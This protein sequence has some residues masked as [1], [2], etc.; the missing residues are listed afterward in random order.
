M[1]SVALSFMLGACDTPAS[2]MKAKGAPVS[3]QRNDDAPPVMQKADDDTRIA[4]LEREVAALKNE[5]IA[6]RP[7]IAKIDVMEQKF[8]DLS[9]GLDRI[10]ATY[11]VQSNV[12]PVAPAVTAPVA[13]APLPVPAE[14][15]VKTE[16]KK[17]EPKP[18][19][20][21]IT[22]P[23]APVP[24]PAK[25]VTKPVAKPEAK[26]EQKA[27]KVV[28][29]LRIGEQA[30]GTR[31][32]LDL[33]EATKVKYDIDNEEKILLIDIPGYKWN[34][35]KSGNLTKSA[36]VS[37]YQVTTDDKGSHLVV[38]LKKPAK[39]LNSTTI[40]ATAGKSPRA[41]VDISPQ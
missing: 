12:K 39:V 14:N 15:E 28:K 16:P 1:L 11:N 27:E 5:I 4:A 2:G 37:S 17:V 9:L 6:T 23:A 3:L 36:L 7:K 21:P 19:V 13:P 24:P 35:A 22:K 38:Q 20:A 34:A 18:A 40:N 8:K 10:D 29:D 32:V 33:G 25:P 41:V 31:L 30:N 26:I